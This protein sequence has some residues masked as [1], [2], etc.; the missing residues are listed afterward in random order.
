MKKKGDLEMQ[1]EEA[2]PSETNSNVMGCLGQ[3]ERKGS[4]SLVD[5]KGQREQAGDD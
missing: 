3:E 4:I 1:D 5:Y 2:N